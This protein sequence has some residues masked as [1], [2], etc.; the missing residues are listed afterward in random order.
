MWSYG[1]GEGHWLDWLTTFMRH[2]PISDPLQPYTWIKAL[3]IANSLFVVYPETS[4]SLVVQ[5]YTFSYDTTM[6]K[7]VSITTLFIVLTLFKHKIFIKTIVGFWTFL[8]RSDEWRGARPLAGVERS[9]HDKRAGVSTSIVY[10]KPPWKWILQRIHF[11]RHRSPALY[12]CDVD[13]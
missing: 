10:L 1:V 7:L 9:W 2:F 13:Y 5:F 11:L 6:F 3:Q 8:V 12:L 4:I